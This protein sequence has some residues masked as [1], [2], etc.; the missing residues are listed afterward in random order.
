MNRLIV[1]I[2]EAQ[3]YLGGISRSALYE[4]IDGGFVKRI[5]I[6]RRAFVV[7]ESMDEYISSL[8]AA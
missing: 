2:P 7:R 6:G 1:P 8:A 3:E 5:N 4:L